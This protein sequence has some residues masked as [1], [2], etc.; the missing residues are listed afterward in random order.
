MS[1]AS[2]I[3][4]KNAAAANQNFLRLNGDS[5]KVNYMLDT[6]SLSAPVSLVIGHQMATSKSGSDRHLVKVS[7]TALDVNGNPFTLVLNVTLSVPRNTTVTRTM[8]NDAIAQMKEFFGTANVDAL[9]R[10]EV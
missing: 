7:H 9:L 10:G 5:S 6:S 3:V 1:Y 2:T 4:L 8:I